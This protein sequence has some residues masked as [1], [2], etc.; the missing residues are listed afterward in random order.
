MFADGSN[1]SVNFD[2]SKIVIRRK[3]LANI[4]T[5]GFQGEKT[6]PLSSITA[7]QLRPAGA[8]MAGCIQFSILG[9]REFRGGML[10]ATKDENAVLF[11]R[12]Q[13]PAFEA[14]KAEIE[15]AQSRAASFTA[16]PIGVSG[17]L[18]KLASLAER[19]FLTN[20]EFASQKALILART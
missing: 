16:S 12:K 8:F 11:E 10:E 4:I 3:G 18:E 20:E 2:D 13:Q 19:G 15:E 1:G 14:L 6:I 17:E 7:I 5:Q 9:G